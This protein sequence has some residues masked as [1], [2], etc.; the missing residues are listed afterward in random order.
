MHTERLMWDDLRARDVQLRDGDAGLQSVERGAGDV[1]RL[2]P[3][4]QRQRELRLEDR[5][6][7]LLPEQ[8]RRSERK[9]LDLLGHRRKHLLPRGQFE[10]RQLRQ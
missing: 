6:R 2:Q 9:L 3:D 4:L 10:L 5:R 7:R 8:R 1:V